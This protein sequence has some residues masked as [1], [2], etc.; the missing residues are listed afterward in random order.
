MSNN[1]EE[2][3]SII[4]SEL[5]L[6]SKWDVAIPRFLAHNAIGAALGLGVSLVLFSKYILLFTELKIYILV[7]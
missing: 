7:V 1:K 3:K 4:P 6:S 5:R 2:N